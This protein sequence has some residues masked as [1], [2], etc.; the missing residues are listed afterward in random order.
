MVVGVGV[1]VAR[2]DGL[3]IAGA[4]RLGDI[5]DLTRQGDWRE[6]WLAKAQS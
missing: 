1:V 3:W 2:H 4:G 5:M 6:A